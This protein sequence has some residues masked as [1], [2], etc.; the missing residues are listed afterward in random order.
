MLPNVVLYE[1]EHPAGDYIGEI[2]RGDLGLCDLLLVVGTSMKV[3]GTIATIKSF[4]TDI[5]NRTLPSRKRLRTV[6]LNKEFPTQR[7]WSGVFDIWIKADCQVIASALLQEMSVGKGERNSE[8]ASEVCYHQPAL[9]K[10]ARS[11][12]LRVIFSIP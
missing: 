12:I 7:T 2:Q 11:H 6:Y 10:F 4:A 3:P 1:Q 8:G 5:H 9:F